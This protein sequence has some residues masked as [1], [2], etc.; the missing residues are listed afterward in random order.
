MAFWAP[1]QGAIA[2]MKKPCKQHGLNL[3]W[4]P[5]RGFRASPVHPMKAF[6]AMV[7]GRNPAALYTY[8]TTKFPR[9][10]ACKVMQDSYQKHH[11]QWC[12]AH[13]FTY[14]QGA[15]IDPRKEFDR[16]K[17]V[18]MCG[19]ASAGQQSGTERSTENADNGMYL[20]RCVRARVRVCA[21]LFVC[22][23]GWTRTRTH[24]HKFMYIY[25]Y[26]YIRSIYLDTQACM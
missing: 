4:R 12:W 11:A 9:V 16:S 6:C 19:R 24:T 14:F 23:Y 2:T 21:C 15:S 3:I 20:Q 10:L 8:Y 7:D 18:D 22:M 1:T 26:I 13:G 25:I 5:V 17:G